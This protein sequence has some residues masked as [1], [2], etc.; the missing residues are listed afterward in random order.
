LKK[1]SIILA[2]FCVLLPQARLEAQYAFRHLN[3][4]DGLSQN[5]V[6]SI[7]QDKEG[8]MWFGTR[9]G[10]NRYD[11]YRMVVY[12]QRE[13]DA[14][15][16][17]GNDIRCLYFDDQKGQLWVGTSTGLSLYRSSQDNFINF[18]PGEKPGALLGGSIRTILRD[19]QGRL[20]VGTN[21]GLHVYDD[22]RMAFRVIRGERGLPGEISS[23]NIKTLYE[24]LN[25]QLWVGTEDGLNRLVGR[26][27][28][29]YI[30]EQALQDGGHVLAGQHIKAI[31]QQADSVYW[32][33]THS[34]GLYKW[35]PKCQILEQYQ[36]RSDQPNSLSHN[37]IRTLEVAPDNSLWAGTF[38]GLNR[39]RPETN[40]FEVLLHEEEV[41]SSLSNSSIRSIF[42]DHRGSMWVGT[43]YGGVDF[44]DEQINRFKYLQR[45]VNGRGLSHNVVSSFWE[46]ENGD[47]W[48]G[49]EGGGLNFLDRKTGQFTYYTSK[50]KLSGNNVKTLAEA[51][52]YLWVGLFNAGLDRLDLATGAIR[53]YRHQSG[54]ARGLPDDNI[55]GLL[56]EGNQLWIASYGGGLARMNMDT[57]SFRVYRH[58]PEDTTSLSSDL[59]RVIFKDR[60]GF[61]WLGTDNGLDRFSSGGAEKELQFQH[62][63]SGVEV[64]ALCQTKDGSIWVGTYSDGLFHLNP[65]GAVIHQFTEQGGLP[66]HTIFGILEGGNQQLWLSTN[67]GLAK[68]DRRNQTFTA[69][70]YSD[71]IRN[72]EF[73]F[74]AYYKTRKGELLFGGTQGV[75]LFNPSDIKR[76]T[77]V[78]P[79]VFTTLK[80]FNQK[81]GVGS[82]EGLLDQAINYTESLTFAYNRA[83]FTLGFAALD[84]L[85]PS[86]NNYSYLLEGVGEDWT[87][88]K[89]ETEATYTL[90]RPGTYYFRL[91]GG[92]NDGLWN[93]KERHIRIEVQPPPWLTGWAYLAYAVM[94]A[95]IFAGTIRFLRLRHQLELEALEKRQRED[96][97]EAKLR[98]FTNIAHE[99]RTP[100][101][102]ITGPL[103]E[104][105]REQLPVP[106]HRRLVSI[107][108]NAKRLLYLVNQLL[109]FRK[110]EADH[111]QM[112]AAEGNL[113]RFM[114]EIFLSFQELAHSRG[115]D[116]RFECT[117]DEVMVF[118]D[119]DKME[120]VIFNLLSNAFKF[121]PEGGRIKLAVTQEDKHAVIE[122]SDTGR[123]VPKVLQE[124]IFKR[125]YEKEATFRHSFKGT[126]IGL[127][128]SRQLVGMHH[129]S[130][131]VESEEGQGATFVVRLPKGR[132]HLSASE[133]I[134]GFR[135][136]EDIR[137][138]LEA[139]LQPT[140]ATGAN[141][142][143]SAGEW[144]GKDAPLLL[145][146]EDNDEVRS[147]IE[148]IFK[149]EYRLESA[150][151]GQD[152]LSKAARI[153]PDLIISDVMMPKMDGITLCRKLKTD[154]STSHIPVLL[155]TARTGL[156]FKLEGL[157]TGADDYLTKPFSPKE[158]K[159]RVQNL[160]LVRQKLR[161]RFERIANLSPKEIAVTSADERFLDRALNV[162]EEQMANADFSVEDF[163]RALNVSRP[164][165]FVKIK[166]LTNLTPNNFL[167]GIRL[168]RAAQLL[169]QQKLSVSEVAYQVGFKD[170]R[171]FSKCFQKSFGETPSA[172][173]EGS[174]ELPA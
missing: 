104:L 96:L 62:I 153:S 34:H 155:L 169:R 140:E 131:S 46:N 30:F 101:T 68:L 108:Y 73:N 106:V 87:Y 52:G 121:T 23:N 48:I 115:I 97:H 123:G 151:D 127:A 120:K 27:G 4:M 12:R 105:V 37:N 164:L 150:V 137:Q 50:N 16:I 134:E 118:F 17:A 135:D 124:Q 8:F 168:K 13:N 65:E 72:L 33:G 157:E 45:Q 126:G 47:L 9:D 136:S 158:L 148:E 31:V 69:Y 51:N 144:P 77:F 100:L 78:P 99:F 143:G 49:T 32:I 6:F 79:L 44:Y 22:E 5:S 7:A 90:Q 28:E 2:L 41:P 54:Q 39:Y 70:N 130:I 129:G 15:A 154:L 29:D 42:F 167:K 156:I 53:H 152:G 147:F 119:R 172:F 18:L 76:N 93:P 166:A 139:P 67:N 19:R 40:G 10:L 81:V 161:E 102:L 85:N 95:L 114:E 141:A 98:F 58:D 24:D 3:K 173:A 74:N 110:L 82:E 163:A 75:T 57:E 88:S 91:R 146:V 11:G 149:T 38:V 26:E 84:Y 133:I 80:T 128:V 162:A 122:V 25:G 138:Y 56:P 116:Y 94:L 63:L 170:P 174:G 145:I 61:Y 60:A 35:D 92:N 83:N 103:E 142:S 14:T 125:F 43:Y 159:L 1:S 89:G 109:N 64:Y 132:S 86:N 36:E 59:T 160:L 66:G 171:Y 117:A 20:W 113:V 55:Y 112:Q 111:E 21:R 71:G 107:E 165:L